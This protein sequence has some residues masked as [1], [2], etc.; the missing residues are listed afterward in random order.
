M[1][2]SNFHDLL[3]E[4]KR[5]LPLI[6]LMA[7]LGFGQ[8][9]KKSA[10]CPFHKDS[11]NSFSVYLGADGLWHFKCFGCGIKG[12]EVTFLELARHLS[13]RD[14]IHEFE[15]LAR[16]APGPASSISVTI[17]TSHRLV[18]PALH[19][20][21]GAELRTLARLRC[22]GLDGLRLAS[23]RGLLRFGQWRD[24]PAWFVTDGSGLNAQARRLDGHP[25]P[26]GC[27]ALTLPGAR[28]AWPLGA[29]RAAGSRVILFCEGGPDLLAANHFIA[30]EQRA[31]DAI[32]VAMLG[33][34]LSIPPDALPHFADKRVRFFTHADPAGR[35]GVTRWARQ[36][37]QV[38]VQVDA[39]ALDGLRRAD[40]APAKDLNDVTQLHPD[41]FE[42]HP[43]LQCLV[44]KH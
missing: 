30:V 6:A 17:P 41:D 10:R 2:S 26:Q 23:E 39:I 7:L 37:G 9:A 32:V 5:R 20:G 24:R 11:R 28:A 15:N 13:T 19:V 21:G 16:V 1:R 36:L 40:G 33:A 34:S 22:L 42:A 35:S 14:A 43:A 8:C 3:A 27:K 44:P 38:G 31:D 12:N 29:D 18:L 25:W 4:A